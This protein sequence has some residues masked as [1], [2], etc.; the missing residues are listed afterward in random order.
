MHN[1]QIL[2]K[3]LIIKNNYTLIAKKNENILFL[4]I[5]YINFKDV[6]F[7]INCLVINNFYMKNQ[8]NLLHMKE[9][10]LR[11][12]YFDFSVTYNM[13]KSKPS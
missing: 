4:F 7:K 6:I 13:R 3:G 1:R 9:Y 8:N 12:N 10:I 2:L 11:I 5:N